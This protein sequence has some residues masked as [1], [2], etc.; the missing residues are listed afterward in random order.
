MARGMRAVNNLI[1]RHKTEF[2]F[3]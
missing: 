3:H 1:Q 2:S